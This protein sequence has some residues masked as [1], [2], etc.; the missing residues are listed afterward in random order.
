MRTDLKILVTG[1]GGYV[2]GWIVE[3]LYLQGFLN[4]RAGIRR[5]ASAARIGRF[6]IEIVL[7]DIL[8]EHQVNT[9]VDGVDVVIHCAYGSRDANVKGTRNILE[10]SFQKKIKR[11]VHLSTVSVYGNADGEIDET[12]PVQLTGSEYGDSKIEAEQLC[13]DYFK[14]GLPLTILRPSV[15]Y[16][17]Y[18]KLWVSKFAERLQSGQWGI[19]KGMG[20]GQCNLIYIQD[21]INGILLTLNSDK[22]VGQVFNMNGSDDVSWN[23]YFQRFNEALRLPPL[24]IISPTKVK[25]TSELMTPIKTAAR[26]LLK[27]HEKI[28]TKM[29]QRSLLLQKV[30]KTVEQ[31]MKTSPGN[32][33]LSMFGRKA[34][35]SISKAE[36]MLGFVPAYTLDQGLAMSVEW[37]KHETLLFQ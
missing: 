24:Q 27:H 28:I 3:S 35:Y 15:I 6:P 4:V 32:E 12:I 31:K 25:G 17:P 29:Y 19:F 5:W 7:C 11:L 22:A 30:M 23:D 20:D 2:G 33:E 21:L 36:S 1:A 9:A 13:W 14:K 18:S 16:G 26:Y 37:L 34:H 8:D 10:A